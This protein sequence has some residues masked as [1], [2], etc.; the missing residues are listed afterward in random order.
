MML[1]LTSL[2]TILASPTQLLKLI[3]KERVI[4]ITYNNELHNDLIKFNE[5]VGMNYFFEESKNYSYIVRRYNRTQNLNCQFLMKEP[6]FRNYTGF[7]YMFRD[8]FKTSI[9]SIFKFRIKQK[10]C[11]DKNK[12]G[13]VFD[14][15]TTCLKDNSAENVIGDEKKCSWAMYYYPR[16]VH[17]DL[18]SI[19]CL[20]L[21]RRGPSVPLHLYNTQLK[22]F[23]C[24][25][26]YKKQFENDKF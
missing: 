7:D 5:S 13:V 10:V 23:I 9:S 18:Q 11:F 6:F 24:Y 15:F 25:G 16:I 21:N 20:T 22:V 17:K 1:L 26:K 3:N 19:A 12:C 14:D 8:T 4:P 2:V